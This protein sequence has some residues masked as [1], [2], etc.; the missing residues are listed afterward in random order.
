MYIDPTL[1]NLTNS[2]A[3]YA[4]DFAFLPLELGGGGYAAETS[5]MVSAS[6]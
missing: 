2:E 6:S 5:P 1:T 4:N 3:K